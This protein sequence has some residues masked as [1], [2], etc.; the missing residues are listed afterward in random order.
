MTL[1][2][3]LDTDGAGVATTVLVDEF[4]LPP[5]HASSFIPTRPGTAGYPTGRQQV[6]F[7]FHVFVCYAFVY[8]SLIPFTCAPI[9]HEGLIL[10]FFVH[11]RNDS[12]ILEYTT[13]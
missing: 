6:R 2:R 11:T 7:M 1:L 9:D 10:Y 8:E 12:K 5:F 13:Q 3:K 4:C